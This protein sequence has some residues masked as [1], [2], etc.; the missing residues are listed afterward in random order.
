MPPGNYLMHRF[1]QY[2]VNPYP[3]PKRKN[4]ENKTTTK[5]RKIQRAQTNKK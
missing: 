3:F 5:K 4:N 2:C 1:T